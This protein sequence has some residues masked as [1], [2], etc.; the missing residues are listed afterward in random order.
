MTV[1]YMRGGLGYQLS[2]H[3]GKYCDLRALMNVGYKCY[4]WNNNKEI[5]GQK[6]K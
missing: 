5:S 3:Q 4:Y 1:V 2:F 6:E